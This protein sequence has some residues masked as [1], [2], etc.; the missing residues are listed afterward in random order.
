MTTAAAVPSASTRR[1]T[2]TPSMPG[3]IR[4]ST[5]STSGRCTS[6]AATA[7]APS[8]AVAT[9]SWPSRPR[10][11]SISSRAPSSLSASTSR[12]TPTVRP[13]MRLRRRLQLLFLAL[14]LLLV[15]GIGLDTLVEAQRNDAAS[16]VEDQLVPARDE[17]GAL[18][19]S[20]VDQET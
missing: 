4:W 16:V 9:M 7:P 20:L 10:S 3:G 5:T 8:G 11:R 2:S 19:T 13:D 12:T 14:F 1:A 6:Q 15:A 18:R 17:L